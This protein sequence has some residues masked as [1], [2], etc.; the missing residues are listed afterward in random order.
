[1]NIQQIIESDPRIKEIKEKYQKLVQTKNQLIYNISYVEADINK[2][3]GEYE[4][5]QKEIVAKVETVI[6]NATDTVPSEPPVGAEEGN[7]VVAEE[8][9]DD[10]FAEAGVSD[11]GNFDT[12]VP[13]SAENTNPIAKRE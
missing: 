13:P 1:M 6:R 4:V 12:E 3:M 10:G 11:P 7:N 9:Q 8:N 5:V 2:L